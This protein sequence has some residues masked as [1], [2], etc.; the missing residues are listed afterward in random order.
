MGRYSFNL[1]I[2]A[3]TSNVV[4]ASPCGTGRRRKGRGQV[5]GETRD[6]PH[7]VKPPGMNYPVN[8]NLE[9]VSDWLAKIIVGVT[10]P[11][12]T[13]LPEWLGK[14]AGFLAGY[15]MTRLYLAS[16]LKRAELDLHAQ[17]RSFN[18][19]PLIL[20]CQTVCRSQSPGR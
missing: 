6:Q 17:Q 15:L 19:S 11:Q 1:F 12:L 10:L 3:I 16:A 18:G 5:E 13:V 8:T 20:R 7:V 9:Q 2:A 4:E 14:V